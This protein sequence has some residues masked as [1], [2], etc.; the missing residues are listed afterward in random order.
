MVTGATSGIGAVTAREL[1]G[2]GATVLVVGRSPRKCRRQAE[3]L[4]ALTG[5]RVE[6]LVADLSSQQEVRRLAHD[7]RSRFPRL[8]VLVNNAGSYFMT[9]QLTVDGLERTL[10]LNHLAPFLLTNLLLDLLVASPSARV[11]NVSSSAH[12]Q[13]TIDFEDLQ[14]RQRYDRLEAYARSKLCNLL[15]TYELA[16]RLRGTR[17]TANALHPGVV[18]TNLGIDNGWLRVKL[19]NLLKRSMMSPKEGARTS[20]YLAS[21]P[22]V[23]GLTGRY[24]FECKEV[25]SSEAS[26]DLAASERLWRVSEELTGLR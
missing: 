19:R 23:E 16:R 21:A 7:F 10:A 3:R 26:H 20:V 13:G 1:A 8:D 17:A 5:S 6:G 22:E 25:R 12:E 4:A 14:F 11:V 2:L 24:Y 18:A 9:R 15:F